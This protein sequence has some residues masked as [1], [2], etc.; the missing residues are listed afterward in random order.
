[1]GCEVAVPGQQS[2]VG[3][4]RPGEFLLVGGA[5][6]RP[7]DCVGDHFLLDLRVQFGDQAADHRDGIA[8][9]GVRALAASRPPG[10]VAGSDP[11]GVSAGG[12]GLGLG[13]AVP[14]VPVLAAALEGAHRSAALG[15]TRRRD[16]LGSSLSQGDEQ[17]ADGPGCRRAAVGQHAGMLRW[18]SCERRDFARPPATPA[19]T[20][21]IRSGSSSRSTAATRSTISPTG[22]E[23]ARSGCP[24]A[25]TTARLRGCGP[26]WA[27]GHRRRFQRQQPSVSGMLI[28]HPLPPRA[29]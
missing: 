3:L 26:A 16:G 18:M 24:D 20:E 13:A 21:R 5:G 11:A 2:G 9:V 1:M 8:S 7:A 25:V 19:T 12:A 6:C 23:A 15:A 14:A 29:R 28:G 27:A 4:Q 10:S 22:S 17:V